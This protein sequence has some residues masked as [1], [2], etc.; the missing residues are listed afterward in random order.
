MKYLAMA[1]ILGGNSQSSNLKIFTPPAPL[2][3]K[4]REKR[5]HQTYVQVL[6]NCKSET[7]TKF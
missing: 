6:N 5:S 1:F 3:K 7:G 2:P 4:P